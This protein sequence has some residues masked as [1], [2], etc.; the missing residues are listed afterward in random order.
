MASKGLKACVF[1]NSNAYKQ[2][3]ADKERFENAR[4][5]IVDSVIKSRGC[6]RCRAWVYGATIPSGIMPYRNFSGGIM[7]EEQKAK[8]NLQNV[9]DRI[10]AYGGKTGHSCQ[11]GCIVQCSNIINDTNGEQLTAGF[12]YE[13]AGLFGPNCEIYDIEPIFKMDRF[14][15]DFGFDTIELAASIGVLMDAGKIA[16][17]DYESVL[18][19]FDSFWHEKNSLADDFGIGTEKLANKYGSKRIPTVKDRLSSIRPKKFKRYRNNL[20]TYTDG[21]RSYKRIDNFQKGY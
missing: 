17:G 7:T 16:W 11:A 12:E 10:R 5:K 18:K 6:C 21:C 8:F 1:E 15:D 9:V 19:L 3:Y 2:E 14:C 4:K 20:C 13:T